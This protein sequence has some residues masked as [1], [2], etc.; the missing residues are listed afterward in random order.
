MWSFKSTRKKDKFHQTVIIYSCFLIV[1]NNAHLPIPTSS[2]RPT[3]TISQEMLLLSMKAIHT[4]SGV[5]SL[6][7]QGHSLVT[8]QIRSHKEQ[9]SSKYQSFN[10]CIVFFLQLQSFNHFICDKV[11]VCFHPCH[12]LE[13]SLTGVQP[14]GEHNPPADVWVIQGHV[15]SLALYFGSSEF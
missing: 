10:C 3:Q 5:K 4:H 12:S 7:S 15:H 13:S 2:P 9:L 6:L 14:R 1:A 8:F 11:W